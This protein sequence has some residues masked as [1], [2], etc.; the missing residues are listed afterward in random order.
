MATKSVIEAVREALHEEM[1]RDERVLILGEDVEQGGVFRATEGLLNQFGPDRVLDT[2]LA[3]SAIVG[4]AIGAALNGFRPVA[5]IQFADFIYPAVDQI[6]SE[7]ARLRYR[8]AGAFTCPLVIRAPY[9]AGVHGALYHSQSVEALFCHVPGLKVVT[10]ATPYDAKGLLKAAIRDQDPVLFFEHKKA[11]RLIKGEVPEGDYV[12]PIG[13]AEVKRPGD[14]VTLIAYG[15]MLHHCLQAAEVV[16][17][18]GLSVEVID[19]RTLSPL[20]KETIL[21]SVR[22]TGK[23]LIVHEDNLTGGLGGEVAAIIAAEAF[24][25]L[26]APVTRL[27]SPDVPAMPYSPP[28]EEYCLPNPDKIAAALR[29]LAAH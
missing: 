7:A 29:K 6:I 22:K 5:E 2:P 25:Y 14:H 4:V 3:E 27:A 16:A 28:L 18:D 24:D 17:E 23:V 1:S 19:L 26:D 13:R 11:Y 12:V 21:D 10:P 20:D 8:S 9:G 15:L